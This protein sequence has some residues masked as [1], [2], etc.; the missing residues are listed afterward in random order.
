MKK[1]EHIPPGAQAGQSESG[2]CAGPGRT[3]QQTFDPG[4][5]PTQITVAEALSRRVLLGGFLGSTLAQAAPAAGF[6]PRT[7]SVRLGG[8]KFPVL[9]WGKEPAR[10]VMLLHGFPQEPLTWAPVAE[11]L[12]SAGYQAIV[13]WLRGYVPGNRFAPYTFSQFASDCLNIA[14]A[15]GLLQFDV[16]GFGIGG[17]LAW[18]LAGYHPE[19]VTSITSVRFPHPAALA[20]ACDRDAE[21]RKKWLSLQQLLGAAD[22]AGQANDLLADDAAGLTHLLGAA[23]LPQSFLARYVVRMRHPGAL[24]AALSWD[25]A[26]SLE[27]FSWVPTV[28][29]PSL[30]IWSEGPGVTRAAARA[31]KDCVDGWFMEVKA[32]KAGHFLLE[33]SPTSITQPL[34]AWLRAL[35]EPRRS[36]A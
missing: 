8:L 27:E 4:T 22:P 11:R 31:S 28:K 21:T 1:L 12:A 33:S 6:A 20:Y 2:R 23:G 7:L 9:V 5:T 15:L 13:P 34:L 10:P 17:A 16:A 19:R 18:V 32:H 24:A 29:V 3:T 36:R 25:S 26:V 35:Q 30:L 14:D